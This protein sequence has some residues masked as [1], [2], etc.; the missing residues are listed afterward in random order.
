MSHCGLRRLFSLSLLVVLLMQW[1][2]PLPT[3]VAVLFL[4]QLELN[5]GRSR[6][7]A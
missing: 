5:T 3:A 6:T 1:S 2:G 7:E 4:L